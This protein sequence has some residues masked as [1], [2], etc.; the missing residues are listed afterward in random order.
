MRIQLG[1]F[2][3]DGTY[4]V[5]DWSTRIK[6]CHVRSN[7]HGYESC[8]AE[9]YVSF[10]EAFDY[11]QQLGPLVLRVCWGSYRVWEG[12]LEDPTQFA[13]TQVGL[14][15]TAFGGWVAYNDAPYTALW[16]TT[17]FGDWYTAT[18]DQLTSAIPE[19]YQ[20]DTNDRLFIAPQ[21]NATYANTGVNLAVGGLVF[22][23]PDDSSRNAATGG[24][25]FDYETNTPTLWVTRLQTFNAA[26]T[27][28]ATPWSL[29][30][31]T[32][33]A[34]GSIY[35]NA[36]AGS[37]VRFIFE[38]FYNAAAAAY[39]GETGAA[40]LKI[41]NVRI[42]TSQLNQ[43]DT[44]WSTPAGPVTGVQVVTPASMVGIYVGQRLFI[45][46]GAVT[47]AESVIV[48]AITASTFT[49]TFVKSQAA[50]VVIQALQ[51][52]PDEIIKDCVST[53]NTLNSTQV[54]SDTSLIQSQSID[55]DEL[56]YEDTYPTDIINQMIAKSD[57]RT[58]PLQWVAMVYDDQTLIVRPRGTGRAWYTDVTS[59]DVVRTLTQLYNSVYAVYKDAS[60]KHNL[61]TAISADSLSVTKFKITRRK[62]IRVDTTNSVQATIARDS[63]LAN[64]LD[65]IPRA[66]IDLDRV[67]DIA[68]NVFPLFFMRA[69]DTLTIRN[70]PPILNTALYDKIRTLVITRVDVDMVANTVKLDLEVPMP[71]LDV[72]LA[73]ALKGK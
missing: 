72:Q 10:L 20:M 53:L 48:T 2:T 17:N 60:N 68:G 56:I 65:P 64:Q 52:Y 26:G 51:V 11:Y 44:T 50:G 54:N 67:F 34:T 47:N 62:A 31:T 28:I 37:P 43:V 57:N 4:L 6:S 3:V 69:D 61:R 59:L 24:I 18:T 55:L 12:R 70:F 1:L 15:I 23:F 49:A 58:T 42:T 32:A 71:N 40:Y 36:L 13:N 30:S 73:R 22:D 25:Q 5:V 45:R 19:R 38:V 35:L 29:A 33:L 16:S 41:T 21:K 14:K 9:L 8:E 66:T 39:A 63:V 27:L 7:V 46:Q